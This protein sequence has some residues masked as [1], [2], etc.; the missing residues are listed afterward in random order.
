MS[1]SFVPLFEHVNFPALPSQE[2]FQ[3][4]SIPNSAPKEPPANDATP[5]E[6]SSPKFSTVTLVPR[7][8]T[9]KVDKGE[10][11]S[12]LLADLKSAVVLS[13]PPEVIG[14]IARSLEELK[15]SPSPDP[16]HGLPTARNPAGNLVTPGKPHLSVQKEGDQVTGILVE[17]SCGEFIALD[18][19]Y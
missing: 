15:N 16:V 17:C 2:Q 13:L 3:H 10:L 8:R 18:C 12:K 1:D 6:L 19:I 14:Q 4:Y 7:E 11:K 5:G 9:K